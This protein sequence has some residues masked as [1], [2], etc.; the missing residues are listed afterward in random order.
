MK[1]ITLP[2]LLVLVGIGPILLFASSA[3]GLA[4]ITYSTPQS[5]TPLEQAAQA[6]G[7]LV[8]KPLY[9]L[10]SLVLI[11]FLLGQKSRDTAALRWSLIAFLAGETFCAANFWVF[12][13]NSQ[14]SEYLHSFGM[15]LAF[16]LAAFTVLEALDKRL[17]KINDGHCAFTP[18]C[19]VCRRATPAECAVR[20]IAQV[21]V[22]MALAL[23][24]LPLC[25][26]LAPFAY[27]TSVFGFPYSYA[28]QPLY[29]WYEDRALPTL[30]LACFALAWIPLLRKNGSPLPT[31]TKSFFAAGLGALGFSFFRLALSSIF[32]AN[33]VWFEF[34][35]EG[36]ELM[37]MLGLAFLLWQFRS[38]LDKTQIT[39]WLDE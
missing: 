2:L 16:G 17:L 9:M 39:T 1:R 7:G 28:R 23:A 30:A 34:W 19:G 32:S 37:F 31:W 21:V 33:L 8:I 14:I 24:V 29:E 36:T 18:L 11:V 13:H 10:V 3:N 12:R 22:P 26:R 5:M 25:A 35:E 4:S 20:R 38:S 6:I 15:A 27:K